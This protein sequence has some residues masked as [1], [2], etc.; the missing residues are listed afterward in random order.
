[1]EMINKSDDL[2]IIRYNNEV[3]NKS[4]NLVV[5]RYNNGND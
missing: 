1:M 5:I 2:V 3:I 4:D